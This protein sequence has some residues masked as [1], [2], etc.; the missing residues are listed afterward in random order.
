MD[1]ATSNKSCIPESKSLECNK[2]ESMEEAMNTEEDFLK[3]VNQLPI[4]TENKISSP[5]C[6][7]IN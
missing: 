3:F 7:R 5:I 1:H 6:V 2:L 4:S